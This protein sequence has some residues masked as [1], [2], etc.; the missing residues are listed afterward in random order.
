MESIYEKG[1]DERV[2]D[3]YCPQPFSSIVINGLSG[4]V[5]PCCVM[6]NWPVKDSEETWEAL[7]KEFITGKGNLKEKFCQSCIEQEKQQEGSPR[8]S[9]LQQYEQNPD[10][11]TMEYNAPS[12]FCNLKCHMCSPWNSSTIAAENLSITQLDPLSQEF[13]DKY[14]DKILVEP[15][16]ELPIVFPITNLKLVGGETLAI[17][18]NYDLMQKFIDAGLS[19]NITLEITTN[20]TLTPKFNGW[21]IF[22]YISYF[23]ECKMVISI[24]AWGERNNYLRYP[25]KW[26]VIMKNAEKF[27]ECSSVMFAST[28]NCL[29]VGY[30]NDVELGADKMGCVSNFGALVWGQKELYT[31]EALPLDIREIYLEKFYNEGVEVSIVRYLEEIGF[32]PDL[33]KRMITDL[34]ERDKYR[35]TCLLDMFPEWKPYYA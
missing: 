23:K 35:E 14:G 5:Q 16:Q 3:V 2:K 13:S 32:N 15:E 25:S 24:E 17:K 27:K 21:D 10:I 8:K 4:R 34:I 29:N 30:L 20:A 7:K 9:Y 26:E 28:V 22:D 6:K 19:E 18:Q 31:I 33:H 12:N 1:K 11:L